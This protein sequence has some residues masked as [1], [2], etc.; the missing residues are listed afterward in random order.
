MLNIKLPDGSSRQFPINSTGFDIASSISPSLGKI[1]IAV[2]IDGDLKD[3]SCEIAKDASVRI[4]TPDSQEGIEIIRH[5]A[6]HI[7]AQAVAELFPG[8][9]ATIGPVIE[10]GFYYDFAK[11]E[12]FTPDDL[13]TIEKRMREIVKRNEK[14]ERKVLSRQQAVDYFTSLNEPYKVEIIKALPEGEE[15]SVYYQGDFADL[16][17]GPHAPSTGKLKAFKLTKIAGAYWRGDSKNQ[18]L[19]RIYGT[20]W[21]TEQQL[22]SYIEMLAEAEKRDHRRLGKEMNLFHFQ[23]EAPGAVFWHPK[24]WSLFQ[25]LVNYMR[26]TQEQNG[27]KEINTP[28]IMDY[29]LWKTSGHADKFGANMFTAYAGDDEKIYA[30]KPMNCPGGIQVFKQGTVSYRDLPL[31]LAEFGKV[32]RY[33]PSGSLHGLLRVREFTQD[34]AHIFCTEDQIN[35]ECLKMCKLVIDIYADFGFTNVRIKFSDRPEA[36]IGDDEMWDKA[37]AGLKH[38]IDL[39]GLDYT[40]NPGEGAFYGPKIEFV[41]KDAIGRDWQLGTIQVDFNLPERFDI[42]YIAAD[43]KKHR[44]VMLHRAIFGSLERFIGILIEHY[45]GKLPLWLA[46]VQAIVA[47]ITNDVNEYAIKVAAALRGVGCKVELDLDADKINY[48]IRKHSLVKIPL[49]IVLGKKEAESGTV[50]LRRLGSEEQEVLAL[51]EFI[52]KLEEEMAPPHQS[53][54]IVNLN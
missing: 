18:Q 1:A 2:E 47:P 30:V 52:A 14:I 44:P 7:M 27:Y 46:P 36:R 25:Q 37:E 23:E 26:F 39:A 15:I 51:N 49:M 4:I 10:N 20:A 29:A 35:E 28:S 24:G 16:C 38:A 11:D 22:S 19:Q 12:P 3:L 48:K 45:A 40:L 54:C 17:R 53:G 13:I 21:A 50:S 33:E 34:D 5:D 8:T 42:A 32:N 6:A 43:G 31:R 41:L 9:K